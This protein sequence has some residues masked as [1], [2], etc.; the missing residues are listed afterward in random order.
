MQVLIMS[1]LAENMR[2]FAV[3][4][5]R[6]VNGGGMLDNDGLEAVKKKTLENLKGTSVDGLTQDQDSTFFKSSDTILREY[7]K[8]AISDATSERLFEKGLSA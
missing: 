5:I 7:I 3:E 6:H 8:M 4:I 1:A 2:Q